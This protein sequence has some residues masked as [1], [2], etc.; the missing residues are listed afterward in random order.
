MQPPTDTQRPQSTATAPAPLR[1]DEGELYRRYQ[2]RLVRVVGRIVKASDELIEDACQAAWALLLRHQPE[3]SAIFAWLRV[4]ALR[5]AYRLCRAEQGAAYLED[6]GAA[7]G[8]EAVI[9][10]GPALD[11]VVE[12]RQ[13]L[14]LLAALPERQR[15]DLALMVAGFSYREIA[16][17]TGGRTFTNVNK[18]LARARARLRLQ[19]LRASERANLR[20]PSSSYVR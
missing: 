2:R 15:D 5:E 11:D 7:D 19:R 12:V 16:A 14:K 10:G 3:R 6:L 17:L 13:A 4:V 8:W 20:S 9:A 18:H 1:G